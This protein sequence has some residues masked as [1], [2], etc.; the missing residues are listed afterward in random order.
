MSTL[1]STNVVTTNSLQ[2]SSG[3]KGSY[4]TSNVSG[5]V[6]NG[7]SST[8]RKLR[9]KNTPG[10]RV[11]LQSQVQEPQIDEY[12]RL[13]FDGRRQ[14]STRVT[15]HKNINQTIEMEKFEDKNTRTDRSVNPRT[16]NLLDSFIQQMGG[17]EQSLSSGSHVNISV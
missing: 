10:I 9:W 7:R 4:E 14:E 12:R 15:E 6:D 8:E 17:A 5:I 16:K 11:S 3:V 2:T 13:Q 1:V